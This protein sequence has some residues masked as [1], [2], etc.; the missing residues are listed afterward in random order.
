V[1]AVAV[2]ERG[3]HLLLLVRRGV[4]AVYWFLQL[5]FHPLLAL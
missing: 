2:V 3:K 1:V 4:A 5:S